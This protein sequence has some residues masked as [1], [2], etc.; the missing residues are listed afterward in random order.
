[1]QPLFG[2]FDPALEAVTLPA[3][4]LDE[5]DPGIGLVRAL[6]QSHPAPFSAVLITDIAESSFRHTQDVL[7]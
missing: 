1:M 3:L 2:R 6:G 7:T 5:R 4:W